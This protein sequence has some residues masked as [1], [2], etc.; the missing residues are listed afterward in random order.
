MIGICTKCKKRGKIITD[1]GTCEDCEDRALEALMAFAMLSD[2]KRVGL[3]GSMEMRE[4]L[5]K[6]LDE[7]KKEDD[8]AGS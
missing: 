5:D 4:K 8:D 6:I 1:L 7:G 2:P 3:E